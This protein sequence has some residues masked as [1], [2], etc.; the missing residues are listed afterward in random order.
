ME[1]AIY[2]V[3]G[4][5]LSLLATIFGAAIYARLREYKTK[6]PLNR[7]LNFGNDELL[8][9][10]PPRYEAPEAILPR[11]ST[12]D[13]LAMNNF[14]GA[15]LQI[16]WANKVG[17]RDIDHFTPNDKNRNLVV[18]CSP[19]S[20]PFAAVV[21][22]EMFKLYPQSR[23]YRVERDPDHRVEQDPDEEQWVVRDGFG[24]WR[25]DTYS[26][27]DGFR[28]EN[29]VTAEQTLDDV[30]V[31][32]KITNPWNKENKIFLVAGVRGIGTWGA[33]ECINKEWQQI[34][35]RMPR[36]LKGGDFSAL[37]QVDYHNCDIVRIRV[38]DCIYLH[39]QQTPS[40]EM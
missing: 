4:F 3:I 8:Y 7:L 17:V 38:V 32:S 6:R 1:N 29:L 21:Q 19:K 14:T 9:I 2:V 40:A 33:A 35:K 13:F 12:E 11:T 36:R 25:S 10:F 34:Y 5:F 28:E 39:P 20:N 37:V 23:F 18:I 16:G 31:I 30:A 26:Q 27:I 24:I 22:T 15:L